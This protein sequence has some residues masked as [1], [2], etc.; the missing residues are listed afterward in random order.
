MYRNGFREGLH[1]ATNS[2]S[3]TS[4]GCCGVNPPSGTGTGLTTIEQNQIITPSL[5]LSSPLANGISHTMTFAAPSLRANRVLS[6]A[7]G[8][9]SVV[10]SASLATTAATSD[11]VTIQGATTLSHCSLTP[12]NRTASTNIATT[13]ISAKTAN[14]ITVT[15]SAT[16]NMNFDVMCTVN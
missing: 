14:Q 16:A 6:G 2:L 12:T 15:H 1:I 11:S 5:V 8:A 9:A 10:V 4:Y 7:D 13:F 3:D